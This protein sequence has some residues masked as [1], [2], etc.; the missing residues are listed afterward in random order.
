MTQGQSAATPIKSIFT[1]VRFP[2]G[3]LAPIVCVR[4]PVGEQTRKFSARF[5]L[6]HGL[7]WPIHQAASESYSRRT[8]IQMFVTEH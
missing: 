2:L 1:A 5:A 3:G 7:R 4:A 6:E 8:R